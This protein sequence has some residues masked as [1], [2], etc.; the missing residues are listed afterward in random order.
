MFRRQ[1]ADETQLVR[2]ETISG[3]GEDVR[4]PSLPKD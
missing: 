3:V 4:K 1:E 2:E